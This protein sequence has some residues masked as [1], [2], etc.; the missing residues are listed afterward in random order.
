MSFRSFTIL[1]AKT[2][3]PK[4]PRSWI[5]G[6]M[7]EGLRIFSPGNSGVPEVGVAPRIYVPGA[8]VES[9]KASKEF[10]LKVILVVSQLRHTWSP[11]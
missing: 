1:Q 2:R 5:R 7:S 11:Q 4:A 9:G 8:F 3:A 10:L 6:I